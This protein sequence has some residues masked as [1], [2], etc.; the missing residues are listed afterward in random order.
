M[1]RMESATRGGGRG[2]AGQHGNNIQPREWLKKLEIIKVLE[3]L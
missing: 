3:Q 2:K 1:G